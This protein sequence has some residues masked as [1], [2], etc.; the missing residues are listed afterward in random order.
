[1]LSATLGNCPFHRGNALL[2]DQDKPPVQTINGPSV[3]KE[4]PG[5]P[6]LSWDD[7]QRLRPFLAQELLTPELDKMAPHLWMMAT[8]SSNNVNALHRQVVKGRQIMVTEDPQLHLVWLQDRIHVKPMP[9]YLLSYEFW[10]DLLLQPHPEIGAEHP[11]IVKAALGYLRTY[12]YLI[13]HE[14]DLRIAQKEDLGLVPRDVTWEQISRFLSDLEN[15]RDDDVSPRYSFGELRLS[16]LNFYGKIFLHRFHYE[17][18]HVQYSSYFA[19]FYGPLLFGFAVFSLIL[20]ALQVDLAVEQLPGHSRLSLQSLGRGLSFL[21]LVWLALVI[22]VLSIL[23]MYLFLDEWSF[24]IR[25]RIRR[26]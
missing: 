15:T 17:R 12:R 20:N 16:R 7:R 14:S 21:T 2:P 23:F 9:K 24:A 10:T 5:W 8:Q 19:Q 6:L 26:G 1:M 4:I 25:D 3:T 13:R 18:L 11:D 22:A